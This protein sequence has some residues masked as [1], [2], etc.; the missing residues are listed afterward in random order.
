[1]YGMD[2]VPDYGSGGSRSPGSV[3]N[4][5]VEV[6]PGTPNGTRTCTRVSHRIGADEAG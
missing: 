2:T 5:T 4:N 1:M 6:V 3:K